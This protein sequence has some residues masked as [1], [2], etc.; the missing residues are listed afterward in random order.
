[1]QLPAGPE[2]EVE[3]ISERKPNQR[4]FV[5]ELDFDK[6]GFLFQQLE[7]PEP[8]SFREEFRWELVRK[9]VNFDV[10]A[11]IRF[12]PPGTL[13]AQLRYQEELH[14]KLQEGLRGQKE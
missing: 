7:I 12:L 9:W 14:R 10:V 6:K 13:A 8:K 3:F 5:E 11:E 1:M 2:I 4:G